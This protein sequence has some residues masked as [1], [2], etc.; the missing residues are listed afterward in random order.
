MEATLIN[1]CLKHQIIPQIIY[2]DGW[3]ILYKLPRNNRLSEIHLIFISFEFHIHKESEPIEVY[4][5]P[6]SIV[7]STIKSVQILNEYES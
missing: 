5:C 1:L 7:I 2:L 6:Y 3:V 4:F